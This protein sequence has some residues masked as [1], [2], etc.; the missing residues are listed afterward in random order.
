MSGMKHPDMGRRCGGLRL[1]VKCSEELLA[2][3]VV[4]LCGGFGG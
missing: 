3:G 4:L 2:V 1:G